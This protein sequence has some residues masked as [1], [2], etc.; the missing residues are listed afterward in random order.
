LDIVDVGLREKT[1]A[2]L[3]AVRDLTDYKPVGAH[4]SALVLILIR[5]K[6]A[7]PSLLKL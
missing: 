6:R 7:L 1:S 3:H 2:A 4:P 5:T